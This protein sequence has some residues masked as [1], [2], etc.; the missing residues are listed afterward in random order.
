ML[1]GHVQWWYQSPLAGINAH[2]FLVVVVGIP[3]V[4][5]FYFSLKRSRQAQEQDGEGSLAYWQTQEK[6]LLRRLWEIEEQYRQRQ[7]DDA[8]YD[9]LKTSYKKRLVY[10]KAQLR[11]LNEEN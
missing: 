5:L 7:I 2:L 1:H 3:A 11:R 6:A 8:S 4:L 9:K 10:V